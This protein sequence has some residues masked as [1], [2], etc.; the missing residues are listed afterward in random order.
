[1][2]FLS[3]I[4]RLV[5]DPPPAFLFELSEAGIAFARTRPA[6]AGPPMGFQPLEPGVLAIS[7]VH[8]NVL[9]PDTFSAQLG[10]IAPMTGPKKRRPAVVVLPDY[11]ARV[12]VLDFDSFPSGAEDQLS[13]IRFRLKKTVPFDVDSAAVSYS[14]QPA[15]GTGSKIEVVVAVIALEIIARYEALFRNAGYAP[16][17][18]TTSA[19]AALNLY[20]GDGVNVL[21]K[22]SGRILSIMVLNGSRLK[23]SRCVE[24]NEVNEEEILG[25]L[26]PTLVYVEDELGTK[27]QRLLLCGFGN[28][29]GHAGPNWHE[30]L[31]LAVEPLRSRLGVPGP[32]NAGLL[33]YFEAVEG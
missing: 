2:S 12:A 9:Q 27:A 20:H 26:F 16:G 6:G 17:M 18:V 13:L 3:H 8:D 30:R 31:D 10:R 19:L 15:S 4:A 1:M 5:K 25:V 23:L 33:G 7:P 29:A 21:A 11:A 32:F 14:V 28:L 22:L 24:L